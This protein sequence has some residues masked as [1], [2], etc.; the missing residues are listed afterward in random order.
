MDE[1]RPERAIGKLNFFFDNKILKSVYKFVDRSIVNK[2][3]LERFL[4]VTS[5]FG[6][7][8]DCDRFS[9]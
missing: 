7:R 9:T 3:F 4:K 8:Y 5:N 1:N 2:G 6:Y